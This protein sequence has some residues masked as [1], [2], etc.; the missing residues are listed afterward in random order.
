MKNLT[1]LSIFL[2]TVSAFAAEPPEL[3]DK[4]KLEI[5]DKQIQVMNLKDQYTQVQDALK[6]ASEELQA[7]VKKYTPDGWSLGFDLHFT[8]MQPAAPTPAK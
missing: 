8:P 2:I 1:V 4:Q 7:V 6:K 3:T 5:R